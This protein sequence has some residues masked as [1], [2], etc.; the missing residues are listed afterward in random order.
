MKKQWKHVEVWVNYPFKSLTPG[1]DRAHC[2]C[3][4]HNQEILICFISN[5]WGRLLIIMNYFS[6]A[7]CDPNRR[8]E[9]ESVPFLLWIIT[10]HLNSFLTG[11]VTPPHP[12]IRSWTQLLIAGRL[13]LVCHQIP[14]W[15][16]DGDVVQRATRPPHRQR[17]TPTEA[18]SRKWQQKFSLKPE[19]SPLS[20]L[21][22]LLSGE[23]WLGG[24]LKASCGSTQSENVSRLFSILAS[25]LTSFMLPRDTFIVPSHWC[26]TFY[27]VTI[28]GQ[29]KL[30]IKTFLTFK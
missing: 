16:R 4:L 2:V 14:V 10:I 9:H 23:N 21:S 22:L 12:A 27:C 29:H 30:E 5:L 11:Q 19:T 1:C 26:V 7:I 13:N 25:Y 20:A 28:E 8:E 17:L 6:S 15:G 18:S 24:N 3:D